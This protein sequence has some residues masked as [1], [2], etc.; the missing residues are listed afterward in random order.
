[1][2]PPTVPEGVPSH[3][4]RQTLEDVQASRNAAQQAKLTGYEAMALGGPL[5]A[6]ANPAPQMATTPERHLQATTI[7]LPQSYQLPDAAALNA[8]MQ[9]AGYQPAPQMVP[10]TL[11][12]Q[13]QQQ[14]APIRGY[15]Q[16]A[17]PA[18]NPAV[19]NTQPY[20]NNQPPIQQQQ[21]MM[22]ASAPMYP[23]VQAVAQQPVGINPTLGQVQQQSYQQPVMQPPTVQPPMM[24][25]GPAIRQPQP[26]MQMQ[27]WQ[28]QPGQV[29]AAAMSAPAG[30][31]YR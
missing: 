20:V 22:P 18:V 27:T 14:A 15:N 19:I 26:A 12:P 3:P 31:M 7:S 5:G 9:S 25:Q 13:M 30:V 8:A 29:P 21:P 4:A 28:Q 24:M 10:N 11:P 6:V 2:K 23:G 1:V 17:A 16:V